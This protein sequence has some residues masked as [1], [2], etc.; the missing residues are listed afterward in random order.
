M[1]KKLPR[2]TDF[3]NIPTEALVPEDEQPYE[4]PKHWKWVRLGSVASSSKSKT[5]DFSTNPSYIGLENLITGG[6]ISSVSE[7]FKL[8]STKNIFTPGDVLYGRLRP[9]LD[10]HAVVNFEGVCSTDIVVY[11]PTTALLPKFLEMW[12]STQYFVNKATHESKGINLPRISDKKLALF[13]IP[14]PPL[15]EQQRIVEYI[16]QTNSKIDDVI[17]RL[18]QYLDEAPNRR[19]K[20]IQ[21]GVNGLL[22]SSWREGQGRSID[23]WSVERLGDLG[24]WGGGGTPRKTNKAYW[25]GGTIRWVTPKDMKSEQITDTVDYIT[26]LGVEE[27][28]ANKYEGRALC[29]VTRSGILRR[30]LP[31]GLIDGTFTVNQDMKVLHNVSEHHLVDFIFWAAMAHE[32]SIRETCS[33]SGTTVESI[34]FGKLKAYEISLPS[35]SEQEEIVGIITSGLK[36]IDSSVELVTKARAKVKLLKEQMIS[37]AL[38]GRLRS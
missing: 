3:N 11:Q 33:K 9:Y 29:V 14:L 1:A 7:S 23:G 36:R 30:L 16:E 17:Q 35:R 31:L 12:I 32:A 34:D 24:R 6:G 4:I 20:L 2:I 25:D 38:A 21:A 27:S 15:E 10:K 5:E 37:A 13:P 19:T 8:K 18:E 26:G 28:S 22:T